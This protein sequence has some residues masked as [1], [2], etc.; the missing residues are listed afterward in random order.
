MK[1]ADYVAHFFAGL[2]VRHAF[3]VSG[4]ASLHLIHGLDNTPG[5]SHICCHHEQA[6][7]MAADGY[8]RV[9][10]NLGLA[11][12]TSG[13]GATN[14][15]TGIAGCF[16]DSVPAV[17][18]TGQVSTFRMSGNSGVRQTGFQETPIV[19]ICRSIT[20]YA[21]QVLNPADIKKE[22]Q[23]AVHIAK[24]GRPGPVL[25]D[26]P[27]NVQRMNIDPDALVEFSPDVA[28]DAADRNTV[29]TIIAKLAES[30]RPVIIAGWGLHLAGVEDQFRSLVEKLNVP[31]ALTWGAADLLPASH[32]LRIGT[33]GTHGSRYANFAVQNADFV[34]AL[35]SRLDTKATGS[36]PNTFARS[37][38]KAVVDIDRKE[39][40]K[41]ELYEVK[42]D[43]PVESDLRTFVPAL[44]AKSVTTDF[45][46]WLQRIDQWKSRYHFSKETYD[47]GQQ[48]DPYRFADV[49]ADILPA[50]ANIWVDTGSAIAW[51]MQAFR[52]GPGH[53]VWHDFNNTAMGWALPAAIASALVEPQVP[54]YCVVGDGSLMMNLQELATVVRHN[55]DIRIICLD[56][57]GYSMIQQTQDQWLDGRYIASSID[58]GLSFPN[59]LAAAAAFNIPALEIT[60]NAFLM[61][62]LKR[63]ADHTGPGFCRVAI[64]SACRVT[65]QVKFGRPNEDPEPLLPRDQFRREMVVPPLPASEGL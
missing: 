51:M 53:R 47:P 58:G 30:E 25:V 50:R 55:L 33:F 65:P 43:C 62:G 63:L 4:G 16:Y 59:W 54:T 56:N 35:G 61:D 41:F 64:D 20:K 39:L 9:T 46:P 18:V 37:A 7:A 15:I 19:D 23:K 6:A 14:L 10:G 31:V 36:P 45:S 60:H 11:M 21:V 40:D 26:I 52:P 12:A 17:F 3:V 8:S 13:P 49:L 42:I 1:L 29:Q 24:T 38:W 5:I 22:L 32:A 28:A 57:A 48:V 2:G 44:A 34:L 27:D